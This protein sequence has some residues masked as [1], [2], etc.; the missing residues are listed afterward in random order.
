[1]KCG[2]DVNR[3]SQLQTRIFELLALYCTVMLDAQIREVRRCLRH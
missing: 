3:M 2:V 1:M